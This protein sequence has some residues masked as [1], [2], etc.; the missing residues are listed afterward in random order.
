M[1][2]KIQPAN[3]L[4]DIRSW[5]SRQFSTLQWGW[6]RSMHIE[7]GALMIKVTDG[8]SMHI[9]QRRRSNHTRQ[10]GRERSKYIH[11]N[12]PWRKPL[13]YRGF[14]FKQNIYLSYPLEGK[15]VRLFGRRVSWMEGK[16]ERLGWKGD[17]VSLCYCI[18][19]TWADLP[20]LACCCCSR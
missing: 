10:W 7:L 14:T 6:E 19:G 3:T 11:M 12:G 2:K 16:K 15:E 17:P 8:I 9:Y 1:K 4:H 20:L 5:R 18:A 13:P